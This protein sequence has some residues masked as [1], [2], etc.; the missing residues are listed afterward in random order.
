MAASLCADAT[1]GELIICKP[2]HLK[3]R[4]DHL[5][6]RIFRGSGER[7]ARPTDGKNMGTSDLSPACLYELTR[8]FVADAVRHGYALSACGRE[9]TAAE[10]GAH[11]GLAMCRRLEPSNVLVLMSYIA[12]TATLRPGDEGEGGDGAAALSTLLALANGRLAAPGE[13]MSLVALARPFTSGNGRCGRAIELWLAVRRWDRSP[14][15]RPCVETL[16][17]AP[18]RRAAGT[19]A[20]RRH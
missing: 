20:A 13:L 9:P 17:R 10:I 1:A 7:A 14:D 16:F 15:E 18:A 5:E 11:R 4:R 19:G 3:T 6:R 2:D 12:P 8:T